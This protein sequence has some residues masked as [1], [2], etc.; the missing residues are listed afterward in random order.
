MTEEMTVT[1]NTKAGITAV[2]VLKILRPRQVRIERYP[3]HFLDIAV[4]NTK[5][6]GAFSGIGAEIVQPPLQSFQEFGR[7]NFI[8]VG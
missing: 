2:L 4:V 6:V 5:G 1:G 8:A 7:L 3:R